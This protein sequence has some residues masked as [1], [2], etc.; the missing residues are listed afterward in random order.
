[1]RTPAPA[2]GRP[3]RAPPRCP[4]SAGTGAH[5]PAVTRPEV[6]PRAHRHGTTTLPPL[7][8]CGDDDRERGEL[9][10][11]GLT[12]D[13]VK[14]KATVLP[15]LRRLRAGPGTGPEGIHSGMFP[16]FLGGS[17]SRLLASTR[18]ALVTC[19]RVWDGGMTAST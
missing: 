12:A 10:G 6:G 9:L 18:S 14:E 16:C 4:P 8:Q 11:G 2:G 3:S 1:M 15:T 7:R 13:H 17:V 19:T 5:R